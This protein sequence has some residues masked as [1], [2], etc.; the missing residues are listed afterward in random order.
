MKK[1]KTP[2]PPEFRASDQ[3]MAAT[4]RIGPHVVKIPRESFDRWESEI[5]AEVG[6]SKDAIT[7]EIKRRLAID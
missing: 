7:T 6:F 4:I 2:P 5:A 1:Q 3:P